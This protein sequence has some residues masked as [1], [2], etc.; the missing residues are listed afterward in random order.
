LQPNGIANAQKEQVALSKQTLRAGL[1]D[2]HVRL[3]VAGNPQANTPRFPFVSPENLAIS[4][5]ACSSRVSIEPA[6]R[7][8]LEPPLARPVPETRARNIATARDPASDAIGPL[9]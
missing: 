4:S 5:P 1:I 3:N 9:R 7:P 8:P 6:W 2:D